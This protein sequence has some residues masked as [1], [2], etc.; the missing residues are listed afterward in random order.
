MRVGDIVLLGEQ[1]AF[2]GGVSGKGKKGEGRKGVVTRV[3]RAQVGVAFEEE[4]EKGEGGL[5]GRVWIVKV[6]DDVTFR[7]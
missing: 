4:E 5:D 6:A 3:G 2:G 7:R 1:P